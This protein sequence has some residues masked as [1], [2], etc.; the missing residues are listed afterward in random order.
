[1]SLVE[2]G[3]PETILPNMAHA[4]LYNGDLIFY[5]KI[6]DTYQIITNSKCLNMKR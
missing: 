4:I 5:I 6:N 1:M 3:F 2:S